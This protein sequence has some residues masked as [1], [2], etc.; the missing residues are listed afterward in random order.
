MTYGPVHVKLNEFHKHFTA[1]DK[2]EKTYRFRGD[3]ADWLQ[4]NGTEFQ[5]NGNIY[6]KALKNETGYKRTDTIVIT[7]EKTAGEDAHLH[8][9][10]FMIPLSQRGQVG[11]IQLLPNIGK[12]NTALGKNPY[13]NRDEQQVHTAE[14]T[15]YYLP[16]QEI[17][18]RLPESGYSGYM[19]WYDYETNGDPYYNENPVDSTDWIRSPRAA[20]GNAFSAINTPRNALE[21]TVRQ[22]GVSLGLYAINKAS[23]DGVLDEGNPSN[24]APILKGWNY[25]PNNPATA[26]HIMACDVSA[27]TD[28][29]IVYNKT[30]NTTR[31]DTIQEPTLSYRQLFHLRPASEM[32][33]TLAARSERGEYLEEY[34][35]IAPAGKQI[36]L[37]TEFRHSKVR[38]HESE[39]CYFY[40]DGGTQL[41]RVNGNVTWQRDGATHTPRYIAEL[42]YLIVRS[43]VPD[44]V[45]YAL[46]VNGTGQRIARFKVVFVDIE[47][48]GPT[49]KTIITQQRIDNQ[50]KP[51]AKIN[52]DDKTT[53]LDWDEASY[54]YV[55]T[56]G[57]LAQDAYFKRGATQ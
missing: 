35:Y 28:Y 33:D 19:R 22:E 15:I 8:K 4:L 7:L 5:N 21:E 40:W 20:N 27:Y 49:S 50:Y 32:A 52:F 26:H 6:I 46:T 25:N 1:N 18:L 13:D 57:N 29:R 16:N 45:T 56:T 47:R 43:E 39:L 41:A 37:S 48:Q 44:T 53:H 30:N 42:D 3:G 23:R 17:E 51:L 11:G 54:G 38:S 55:Y 24:P 34:Q 31:I 36:L 12:G 14:R 10:S 2:W 9:D